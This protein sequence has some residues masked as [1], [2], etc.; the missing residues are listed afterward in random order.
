M[1]SPALTCSLESWFPVNPVLAIL[2]P[3]AKACLELESSFPSFVLSVIS[4][5]SGDGGALPRRA[6]L[7]VRKQLHATCLTFLHNPLCHHSG[8]G[9]LAG[10]PDHRQA[11][12]IVET[13]GRAARNLSDMHT[14]TN[15]RPVLPSNHP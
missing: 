5:P 14:R 8:R 1:S 7:A 9:P 13:T 4:P 15:G 2:K 11:N 6:V 3:V 10:G 12:T